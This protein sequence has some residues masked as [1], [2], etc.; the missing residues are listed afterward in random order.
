MDPLLCR[1][2]NLV[3]AIARAH[4]WFG[5]IARGDANGV[6]D[7][8]SAERLCRT[9]VIRVLCLAFLAPTITKA[10]LEG[11]QPVEV[12]AKRLIGSALNLPRLWTDQAQSLRV[13]NPETGPSDS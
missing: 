1:T 2:Q 13:Y 6:G 10:I 9:Y 11:R 7:I 3:K 12:T 8:A 5:R 4:D